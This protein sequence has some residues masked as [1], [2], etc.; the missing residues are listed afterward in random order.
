[1]T[2]DF[3]KHD[4]LKSG[5]LTG[6]N[7]QGNRKSEIEFDDKVNNFLRRPSE[8]PLLNLS[9]ERQK[10]RQQKLDQTGNSR[11]SLS[12]KKLMF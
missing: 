8:K 1:M 4:N 2:G 3:K 9:Q 7:Y 12:P 6:R 11:D 10:R 5:A